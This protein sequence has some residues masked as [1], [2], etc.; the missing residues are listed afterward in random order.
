MAEGVDKAGTEQRGHLAALLI[1]KSCIHA[2]GLGILQVD[3]LVSHVHVATHYHRLARIESK[4]I[5]AEIVFPAHAVVEAAQSVLAVGR[6][7]AHQEEFVH[8]KRNHTSLVVV[9]VDAYAVGD[10]ERLVAAENRRT[11]ISFLVGIIPPRLITRKLKVELSCLHLRLLQAEEIGIKLRKNLAEI[12]PHYGTQ[13]I[14]I[15]TNKLHILNS[16]FLFA[17]YPL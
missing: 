15:P 10:I 6:I 14:N 5:G 9:L 1:G 4:Q 7:D 2:V 11:A 3:F 12:L 16:R 17:E 13:A 8:F